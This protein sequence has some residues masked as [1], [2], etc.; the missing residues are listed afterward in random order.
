MSLDIGDH[1]HEDPA[2]M[3]V[4]LESQNYIEVPTTYHRQWALDYPAYVQIKYNGDNHFNNAGLNLQQC[5]N[6]DVLMLVHIYKIAS[7]QSNLLPGLVVQ[8]FDATFD[9][10]KNYIEVPLAYHRQW[11]PRYPSFVVFNYNGINH[12]M[13]R[14]RKYGERYY[15]ADRLNEFQR[16]MKFF[17]IVKITFVAPEKNTTFHVTFIR[18]FYTHK[19]RRSAAMTRRHLFT[20]DVTEDTLQQ[21]SPLL[22]PTDALNFLVASKKYIHVKR[23]RGRRYLW[24]MTMD[25]AICC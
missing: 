20:I 15:F 21:N 7:G 5:K 14:L 8:R 18:P 16:T 2:Y 19:C 24:K 1:V 17:E 6:A 9:V 22:L 23:S 11:Y 10:H 3:H 12:F 4:L 25:N 13:I